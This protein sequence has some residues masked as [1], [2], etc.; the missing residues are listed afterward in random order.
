MV[1][2]LIAAPTHECKRYALI[3]YLRAIKFLRAPQSRLLIVDNS[4]TPAFSNEIRYLC[5]SIGKPFEVMHIPNLPQ[6][7]EFEA[8]RIGMSQDAIRTMAIKLGFDCWFS[9]EA[10]VICPP[11]TLEFLLSVREYGFDIVRHAYPARQDL[12]HFID[13]MGCSLY[14]V[15]M[16]EDMSFVEGK[17][18]YVGGDAAFYQWSLEK[19]L[20]ICNVFNVLN[21]IHLDG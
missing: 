18:N 16:L 1:K 20:R 12:T 17:P 4:S 9:L 13:A 11:E 8:L 15:S 2:I 10:D 3:P 6:G 5:S 14:P 21:L 19:G 7:Q